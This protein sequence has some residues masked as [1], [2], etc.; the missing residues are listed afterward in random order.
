M[1]ERVAETETI[2]SAL[3]WAEGRLRSGLGQGR[4]SGD[5][6]GRGRF[7]AGYLLA[8]CLGVGLAEAS[9]WPERTLGPDASAEF[10]RR[11]ERRLRGEPLQY[12]EGRAAFRDL[13]L[14]VDRRVFIPRPETEQ[15]VEQV[16]RWARERARRGVHLTALDVG[17]GSGAIALSLAQEGPFER[18]L[19]VDI[20]RDALNLAHWSAQETGLMARLEFREGSLFQAVRP[21]ERFDAIVSNPPYVS[22][23][24]RAGLDPEV[25]D[26]EP[27]VALF[28]GPAGVE[29][30]EALLV[31]AASH[32]KP[33]GL[34]A[35]EIA[36]LQAV[37][38]R[39]RLEQDRRFAHVTT[40]PDLAGL[41]RIVLAERGQPGDA[42][43]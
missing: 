15:L 14:R 23:G 8:G 36:P 31:D 18:V 24:E 28:G 1:A 6:E 19:A 2:G 9:A 20:S 41:E 7:E 37:S 25:R 22:L 16:L 34:L 13:H 42:E 40:H 10:R 35:L 3:R 21:S 11:V 29:M 26:W 27:P 38:V 30:V 5:A 4:G 32:L 39:R 33:G 12:I 17:T 43:R